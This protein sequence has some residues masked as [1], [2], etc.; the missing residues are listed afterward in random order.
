MYD[1]AIPLNEIHLF[2][3]PN[4]TDKKKS[5]EPPQN[6]YHYFNYWR[7]ND[8]LPFFEKGK[9]GKL[10]F[11]QL[12]WV[13]IL[14]SMRE[15]GL[16]ID[17]MKKVC[18]YLFI[19]AYSDNV[20][21]KNLEFNK[22][23]LNEKLKRGSISGQEKQILEYIDRILADKNWITMMQFEINYLTNLIT[24]CIYTQTETGI[25]IFT[26]GTIAEYSN[27]KYRS[28]KMDVIDIEKPHVYLPLRY[29]LTTFFEDDELFAIVGD[30]FLTPE[31]ESIIRE[32]RD[33]NVK[34]IRIELTDKKISRIESTFNGIIEG[35]KLKEIK[36]ILG[37]KNYERLILET[38]NEKTVTVKRTR[39]KIIGFR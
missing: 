2:K 14:E 15:L 4:L 1:R 38:R 36:K 23:V 12:I 19:D 39:K 26:D 11:V 6:F 29:Y 8:L 22:K 27:Q 5:N 10:S 37:L 30:G 34:E 28:H 35:E 31:E 21:K 9:W 16:S 20:P 33:G 24:E 7:R 13:Q 25:L 18:D 32:I 3:R 17:L